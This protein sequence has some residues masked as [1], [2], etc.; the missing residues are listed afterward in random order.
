MSKAAILSIK[1]VYAQQILAGTKDIE[2]RR[3]AMGLSRGDVV[4]VYVSA[5]EQSLRLWFRISEVEKL[6]VD[7]MWQRYHAR[8]GIAHE[9]YRA[10]FEGV[11]EAVGLHVGE[12]QALDPGVPLDE[13]RKLVP[14]FVPPQGIAWLRDEVG[15]F[16]KLLPRLSA[17]L[18]R[19]AFAQTGFAFS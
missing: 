7:E 2:L 17:P 13:I 16:K 5:P 14:D 18:P 15:R 1:P 11:A 3:S 12:L 10:Y 6:S 8:L 4:L 9:D 19:D